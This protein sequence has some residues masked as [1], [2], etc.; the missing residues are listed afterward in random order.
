MTD[1][2][3]NSIKTILAN[4]EQIYWE[5]KG[6]IVPPIYQNSLFAFE[7]WD[8]IDDAFANADKSF[9]Y[10]RLHNPTSR[11]AEKKIAAIAG[12]EDAKLTASG[13]G[14]ISAAILHYV[15]QG[16]H[17]I[18]IK[19]VYGPANTFI[20]TFLKEKC[21]VESTYVDGTSLAAFEQ[22]IQANTKLFY[23][24]SPASITMQLQ[25]L[26]AL[27]TLA[28]SK[29]IN[30][31]I[32]NTWA[33]PLFQNCIEMGIDMEVHSVSKY[34]CGHSDVVAGVIIGKQKDLDEI[35][36]KE[37]ALLGPKMAPFEA[38]LILRSLRT[39]NLR[40]QAHH[41]AG[42]EIAAF[43]EAQPNIVKVHHPG[44][45]S[46]PQHKLAKSQMKGYGSLLSI[47]LDTEDL[48]RIKAF[49]N[50]LKLFHLGVSWGGHESL[51]YA[52]IISYAK[53]LPPDQ[54]AAMGIV[55][56]MIRLSIGLED[57]NDLKQDLL[58]ALTQL[59]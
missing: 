48:S 37:H 55:P 18:T 13:M 15:N 44:L 12:A 17:I 7:S 39:L 4:D 42:L 2:K 43:L 28:K 20:N 3:K 41:K 21:G 57:E 22:A 16:D 29:G 6:A 49:V 56:G 50:A 26:K 9:I 58:Q 27:V 8:H 52:P 59:D 45:P 32:D 38:W 33:T 47:E 53:E 30:T 40:M 1:Q 19:D 14:A 54:F 11:I 10:S 46:F 51:V 23:L 31:V 5:N 35:L 25:D 34:L 36:L 24:E